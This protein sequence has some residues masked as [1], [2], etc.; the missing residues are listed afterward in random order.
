MESLPICHSVCDNFFGW[1]I[2]AISSVRNEYGATRMSPLKFFSV[3]AAIGML[4]G[5]TI[6]Q[7]GKGT[8]AGRRTLTLNVIVHAPKDV[9]VT[10][11]MFD[12][13]D[14]GIVQEVENFRAVE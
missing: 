1:T 3:A 8:A 7:S 13:Y 4:A 14:Q 2:P 11:G 9:E 6:A 5:L 10:K 12:L